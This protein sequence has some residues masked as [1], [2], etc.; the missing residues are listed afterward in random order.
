MMDWSESQIFSISWKAA[1]AR[2]VHR[3]IRENQETASVSRLEVESGVLAA[4]GR[5]FR[6]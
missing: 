4:M 5:L 6:G 3:E 1:R 2:R